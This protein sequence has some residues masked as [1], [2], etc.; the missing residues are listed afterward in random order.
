M[1]PQE[2]ALLLDSPGGNLERR[3]EAMMKVRQFPWRRG[4]KR[5]GL[6]VCFFP[7][8]WKVERERKGKGKEKTYQIS[9]YHRPS[10]SG[11]IDKQDTAELS[12]NGNNRRDAL[13]FERL[14]PGDSN[15]RENRRRV[16]LN[17]RDASH[18]H[19]SLN[20]HGEE[21]SAEGGSVSEE[22]DV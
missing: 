17:C 9:S 2:A 3:M 11:I 18:L 21:Q 15:L 16:V 5:G 20:R 14:A 6:V 12:N 4:R 8:V 7:E 10:S 22:F 13:V 19:G 1:K